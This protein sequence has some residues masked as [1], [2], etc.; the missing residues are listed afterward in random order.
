M[1][2]SDRDHDL[3]EPGPS[4]SA[5]SEFARR[6]TMAPAQETSQHHGSR[7]RV[8]AWRDGRPITHNALLR[9]AGALARDLPAERR[10]ANCCSDQYHFLVVFL[11]DRKS[12][13]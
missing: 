6:D 13:V 5:R 1:T 8:V 7:D 9:D 2:I 4:R 11:A 12:V 10:I 3:N